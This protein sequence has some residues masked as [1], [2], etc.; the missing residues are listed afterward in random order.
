[1]IDKAVIDKAAQYKREADAASNDLHMNLYPG[2]Y[3]QRC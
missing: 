3:V 1:M 2:I